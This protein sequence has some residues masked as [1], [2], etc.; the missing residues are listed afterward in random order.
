MPFVVVVVLVSAFVRVSLVAAV[1][2]FEVIVAVAA[3][4][5]GMVSAAAAAMVVEAVEVEGAVKVVANAGRG[6]GARTGAEGTKSCA[7]LAG[8]DLEERR[9]GGDGVIRRKC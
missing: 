5:V 2:V 3:V 9:V 7:S 6:I 1:A 4:V 8:D